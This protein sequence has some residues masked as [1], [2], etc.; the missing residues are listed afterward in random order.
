MKQTTRSERAIGLRCVLR[1][2]CLVGLLL[3][4]LSANRAFAQVDQGTITGV[5][6]DSTGAVIPGA[7]A[8][9]TNTDSG[10]LMRAKAGGSGVFEFSPIGIGHYTLSVSAPN[11][12][13]TVQENL[14]LDLD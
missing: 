10:L 6:Q 11:F 9:L 7:E 13:T 14:K 12:E 1:S 3:T 4:V 8:S 2:L 5:V